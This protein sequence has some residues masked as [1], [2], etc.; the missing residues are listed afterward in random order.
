VLSSDPKPPLPTKDVVD[1]FADQLNDDAV[2]DDGMDEALDEDFNIETHVR[3][4]EPS[5]RL[6]GD[7]VREMGEHIYGYSVTT[8]S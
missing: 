1:V 5:K 2:L 4:E 6:Q 3:Y 7:S 8:N